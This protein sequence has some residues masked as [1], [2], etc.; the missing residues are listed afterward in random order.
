MSTKDS[1][2]TEIGSDVVEGGNYEVIRQRLGATGEKLH[3][4]AEALNVRRQATFGSVGLVV[5]GNERLRTENNCIPTDVVQ[6]GGA[7]LLG[8]TVFLGLKR[9][10]TVDDVLSLQQVVRGEHGLTFEPVTDEGRLAFL[11]DRTFVREFDELYQYYKDARLIQLRTTESKLL[12]VFQTGATARDVKV[13]RWALDPGGRLTYVDNRGERDHVFPPTHDFEWTATTRADHVQGRHPHVNILDTVFVETIGGDLTVKVENNTAD[14]GGIY[15]EPVDDRSQSLDDAEILYAKRG[16]LLLLRIRPYRESTW[17]HLV[18]NTATRKVDRIDAIGNSCLSLPE[19]HGLIFPGGYYLRTGELK[20]FEAE[21]RDMELVRAI[22]APNGE[23]VLYVFHRRSDG[24]YGLYPYNLIRKEVATPIQAHGWSLFDDGTLVVMRATDEPLRVH[25]VQI[26]STPFVSAEHHETRPNDGSLLARIGNKDLVRGI[27]DALTVVRLVR[28]QRPTRGVYEEL[29]AACRRYA[30]AY[31]WAADAEVGDLR[32]LVDETRRTAELV[33]DE[34]DKVQA[35]QQRAVQVIADAERQHRRVLDDVRPDRLRAVDALLGGMTTLRTHRGHLITLRET[36]YV[37]LDRLTELEQQVVARF[38]E[39]AKATVDFL[40]GGD[41]FDPLRQELEALVGAIEQVGKAHELTPLQERLDATTEGVNLLGEVVAGLEIEDPTQKTTILEGIGEVVALTNRVRAVLE[42]RGKTLRSSEGRAEFGAQFKLYGQAVASALAMCGTPE[43]CDDQLSRMLLQLEELESRFGDLD[44]FLPQLADKREEVVEAFEA[45]KQGLLEERQ[46]RVSSVHQAAAR[47][48]EGIG[49]RARTFKA[50][51]ELQSWF[52]SDPMVEKLRK[53]SEQLRGLGD[54]VKADELESKLKSARQ[55]ALRGLRDKLE[56]FDGGEDLVRLGKH[57]FSV[58]TRPL[59]LTLVPHGESLALHLTGTDFLEPITDER[60]A[61]S[62]PFWDRVVVSES[63]EVYRAEYLAHDLLS[64]AEAN[65]DGLT[66]AALQDAALTE[67]RMLALVRGVAA[68]RYDEGYDRGIHDVDAARILHRLVGLRQTAG[69]LAFPAPARALATLFWAFAGDERANGWTARARALVRL[70]EA[71]GPS[72]ELRRLQ[73]TLADAIRGYHATA[74]FDPDGDLRERWS[75]LAAAYLLEVLAGETVRFTFS[76]DAEALRDGLLRWLEDHGGQMRF[77]DALAPLGDR[78]GERFAV[79]RAWLETFAGSEAGGGGRYGA[80]TALEAAALIVAQPKVAVDVAGGSGEVVVEGLLGQHP[81]VVDGKLEL[82]LDEVLARLQRFRTVDVPGFRAWRKLRA[83]VVEQ[84]RRRL[85]LEEL[86]PRPLTSFVRNQLVDQ[87][88]L[89]LVGDNLAKQIGAAGEGKRTDLMGL[90]LL[91]SP[92]GYGKTTLM[93]YVAN[94]LGLT[95]VKVNGPALGHEVTSLDP[96]EAPNATARQEVEKVGL[97]LEMG[98]NVMLYLDDIQHCNPEFLQKFISLCDAQRRIEGVWKGR[99][100][101]Y[102][103]R[104]KKFC[105]IMAGNP[106][107]ES[108]E[109]FR[110]PDMLANRADTYNL[111][112]ILGG[113][114]EQFAMSFLENAM[115][116]NAALAPLATRPARDYHLLVRMAR[117]EEVPPTELSQDLPAVERADVLAVLRHLMRCQRTLL[118]VNAEYIRSA[119]MEDAYRTEPR[120]Q[121]Q[122]SYRNMN[123]LAEKVVPAMTEGELDQLV[124]DHYRGEAQTLTTGAEA[125]L[126]KLAELRGIQTAE[127]ASRWSEIREEFRRLRMMGG[128]D[129]PATRIAGVLSGM[130]QELAHLGQRLESGPTTRIPA[131]LEQVDARLGELTAAATVDR[132]DAL[133]RSLSG[134]TKALAQDRTA[135]L[136]Q[137]LGALGSTVGEQRPPDLTVLVEELRALR[138]AVESRPAPTVVTQAA[139][140]P[141]PSP[142]ARPTLPPPVMVDGEAPA[143]ARSRDDELRDT[144]RMLLEQA[145]AILADEPPTAESN[146]NTT[147]AAAL[148]VIEQLTVHVAMAAR[149]RLEADEHDAFMHDLKRSVATAVT[150]LARGV[151]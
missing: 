2:A 123:K 134:V 130:V 91:V 50:E 88:Y 120:F 61:D 28:D 8:Y 85:R 7:L 107:T 45:R 126:L 24:L 35:L 14:G 5:Q 103:L 146:G 16:T 148:L 64:A 52:A 90:L 102:D 38:D 10:T 54:V 125:N 42:G 60:L 3:Q 142:R 149:D 78:Y 72:A 129:D 131:L 141:A 138:T 17:R 94:R 34:F 99:T 112:D 101:T 109:S 114:E 86:Q 80:D 79:K 49:R 18:Y 110:I 121:L 20:R 26:W 117:G 12:A 98:N 115:T 136:V 9:T 97:A 51:D 75:E 65:R 69:L 118:Q 104:G 113:R 33:I 31:G 151:S 89:P 83:E 22:P 56:L 53:L 32:G 30:D 37:D 73:T 128:S 74:G 41:A 13:L 62:A 100:R 119:A 95:F 92:P 93:E 23:D 76:H 124:S 116:S 77:E 147:L 43:A 70:R 67:E 66:L 4:A 39:V 46:R 63:P 15:A 36:R 135:P 145:R 47:I 140:A 19:D 108:G 48:L 137:A 105:V 58:H 27:S 81:R 6:V 68:Q 87:V 144:R 59:E 44:E 143:V 150:G 122:G 106:Y 71:L 111:G 132:S 84:Q 29:V 40:L 55:D 127:E 96:A 21:T 57:R 82:R 139:P 1:G 25:P 133:V 11:R